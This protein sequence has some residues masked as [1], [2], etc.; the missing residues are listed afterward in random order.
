VSKQKIVLRELKETRFRL[1]VLRETGLI[2]KAHD[3]LIAENTELI[4]IVAAIIRK[5]AG[6]GG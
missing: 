6:S 2:T 1:R 4:K 3:P 5:V